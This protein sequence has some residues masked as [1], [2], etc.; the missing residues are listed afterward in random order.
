[1]HLKTYVSVLITLLVFSST[2]NGSSS[3]TVEVTSKTILVTGFEPFSSYNVNPSAL[4]AESLNNTIVEDAYIIGIILPVDFEEAVEETL[5]KIIE[6]K[7]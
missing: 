4:V 2:I 6:V 7:P 1:M 5:E 3:K